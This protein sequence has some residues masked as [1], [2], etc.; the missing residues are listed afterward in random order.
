MA[1]NTVT[2]VNL[3]SPI[4]ILSPTDAQIIVSEID[5]AAAAMAMCYEYLPANAKASAIQLAH[6]L[7]NLRRRMVTVQP[8]PALHGC[9]VAEGGDASEPCNLLSM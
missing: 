7:S 5:A 9:A 8:F 1:G 6:A 4:A 2:E 3:D